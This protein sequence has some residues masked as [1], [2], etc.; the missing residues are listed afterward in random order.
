MLDLNNLR[1]FFHVAKNLNFTVAASELFV[2]QPS[3]TKRVKNLEDSLEMKLFGQS[4]GK[5]YLTEEGKILFESAKKLFKCE[6]EIERT[7]NDIQELRRGTLR[8]GMPATFMESALSDLMD[9]FHRQYPKIKIHVNTGNSDE[10]IKGLLE[11][12]NEVV[13][14]AKLEDHPD[15]R[16]IDIYRAK[17]A[18]I[19]SPSHRF[20]Q[21]GLVS[22]GELAEEPMILREAG[23]GTRQVVMELFEQNRLTPNILLETTNPEY[24]KQLVQRGDGVSFLV[25]RTV[26]PEIDEGKLVAV[27][28]QGHEIFIDLY[29]AYLKDKPLSFSAQA[30]LQVF[31]K[32]TQDLNPFLVDTPE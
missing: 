28:I 20:A 31:A 17:I 26:L 6:K 25:E 3:V 11:H 1:F 8:I 19:A 21:A 23:S 4:R 15:I 14:V 22:L 9:S 7:I 10:L 16:S 5:T 32:T 27:P 18:L 12:Q 2:T 29:L 24:I 13:S 30:Y